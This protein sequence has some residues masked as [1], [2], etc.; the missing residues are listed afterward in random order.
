MS[1]IVSPSRTV[2]GTWYTW[3]FRELPKDFASRHGMIKKIFARLKCA[4]RMPPRINF[5]SQ[6]AAHHPI[7]LQD[8]CYIPADTPRGTSTKTPSFE[9]PWYGCVMP[10]HIHTAVPRQSRRNNKQYRQQILQFSL[11]DSLSWFAQAFPAVC[12]CRSRYSFKI[13]AAATASTPILAG[14]F[15]GLLLPVNFRRG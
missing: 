3:P 5:K 6:L 4:L 8:V 14:T 2:N 12:S 15:F 1:N 13:T 10:Y 9:K 11:T 7:F